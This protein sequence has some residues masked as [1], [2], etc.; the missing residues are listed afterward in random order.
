MSQSTTVCVK[1]ECFLSAI[2]LPRT[3]KD[4][5]SCPSFLALPQNL[6]KN[7]NSFHIQISC[8]EV[9]PPKEFL[10]KNPPKKIPLKK[11]QEKSKKSRKNPKHFQTI[12]QKVPNFEN[13]QFPTSHLEAENPFGLLYTEGK[14]KASFK[15]LSLTFLKFTILEPTKSI[16]QP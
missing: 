5:N 9:I 3:S 12:S 8:Y 15:T 7:I 11:I 2:G 16:L 13:I 6:D 10:P 4:L 1:L 14:S